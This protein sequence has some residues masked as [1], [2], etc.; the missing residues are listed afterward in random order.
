MIV[1]TL[2]WIFGFTYFVKYLQSSCREEE[3]IITFL[4]DQPFMEQISSNYSLPPLTSNR[5]LERVLLATFN[6]FIKSCLFFIELLMVFMKNCWLMSLESTRTQVQ[7]RKQKWTSNIIVWK[8]LTWGK[9][10]LQFQF[11]YWQFPTEE[12]A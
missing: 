6:K 10:D 7:K 5:Y 2:E 4:S 9:S 1:Q 3:F 12:T 11:S 8:K